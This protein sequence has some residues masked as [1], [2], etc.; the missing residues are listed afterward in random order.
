MKEAIHT[1]SYITAVA[2][3]LAE[4]TKYTKKG[5]EIFCFHTVLINTAFIEGDKIELGGEGAV[6]QSSVSAKRRYP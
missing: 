3:Q 2:A 4:L 1:R 6:V 5:K